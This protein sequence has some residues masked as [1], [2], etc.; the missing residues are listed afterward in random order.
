MYN[1][2]VVLFAR[3]D[4]WL[5]GN[6]GDVKLPVG[7]VKMIAALENFSKITS[8]YDRNSIHPPSSVREIWWWSEKLAMWKTP[9]LCVTL[10]VGMQ[11][12]PLYT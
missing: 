10:N 6:G 7:G 11:P 2:G 5:L 9:V 4:V 8:T 1:I 3:I 12:T